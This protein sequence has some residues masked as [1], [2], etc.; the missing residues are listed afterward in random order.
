MSRGYSILGQ[1]SITTARPAARAPGRGLVDDAELQ[2]YRR[3]REPVLLLDGLVDH[4]AHARRADEAVD[5][6]DVGAV[7]D[8]GEAVIPGLAG[9]LSARGCTGMTRIPS[10]CPSQRET[11]YAVRPGLAERPT[12]AH[13]PGVVSRSRMTA[14][15]LS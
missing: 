13:V 14:G 1:V 5:D 9:H 3:D 15:S 8:V 4:R 10:S 6:V 11:P 12:T 2:P 7:R